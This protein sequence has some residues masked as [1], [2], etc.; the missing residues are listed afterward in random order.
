M[1][2]IKKARVEQ[3]FVEDLV[4]AK[5]QNMAILGRLVKLGL[6]SEMNRR[7]TE[8]VIMEI[9]PAFLL[10]KNLEVFRSMLE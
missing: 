7:Q 10:V 4:N 2:G 3:V 6:I 1:P 8:N 9:L 5:L